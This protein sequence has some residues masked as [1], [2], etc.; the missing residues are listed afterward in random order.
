MHGYAKMFHAR[1]QR[2]GLDSENLRSAELTGNPSVGLIEN[3]LGYLG[4]IVRCVVSK[5]LLEAVNCRF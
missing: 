2:R 4:Q 1:A 5:V 3:A